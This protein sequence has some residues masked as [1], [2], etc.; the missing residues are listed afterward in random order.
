MARVI[1]G[2]LVT[3]LHG[4]IGGTVFQRNAY[5]H[6]AKNK[7]N[8][9]NPNSAM[10]ESI[11]RAILQCTQ[12]WSALLQSDRDAWD[13]YAAAY[14]QYAKF[15]P[16]ARLSGYN[17]YLLRNINSYIFAGYT[18]DTPDIVS[19]V[20]PILA[21]T[22]HVVSPTDLELT[23][24]ATPSPLYVDCFIFSSPG[25]TGNRYIGKN[26]IRFV[27]GDTMGTGGKNMYDFY[28]ATFNRCPGVG[29]KV[30]MEFLLFGDTTGA[31]YARQK[32]TLIIT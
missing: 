4:K 22:L 20:A 23:W 17:V 10:Q 1:Y 16:S 25:C 27:C 15:N 5:G 2:A 6:T 12:H 29:E 9:V 3:A 24:N 26:S 11:K 8:M 19:T 32:F 18:L 13:T 30:Y 28:M 21:P 31:V 14:P 7:A